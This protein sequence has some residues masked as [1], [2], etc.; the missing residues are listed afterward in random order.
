MTHKVISVTLEEKNRLNVVREHFEKQHGI[1]LSYSKTVTLL[2][3]EWEKN[4]SYDVEIAT[5]REDDRPDY[6][7]ELMKPSV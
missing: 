3:N 6:I 4:N 1:R 5:Q 2:I 7:E